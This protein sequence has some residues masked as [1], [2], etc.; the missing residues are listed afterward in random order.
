LPKVFK[1]GDLLEICFKY[2]TPENPSA[3]LRGKNEFST[4]STLAWEIKRP[5][6][7]SDMVWISSKGQ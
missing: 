2:Y 3:T 6:P 5:F 1:S 7:L 4:F